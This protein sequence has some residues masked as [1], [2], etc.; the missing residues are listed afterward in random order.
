MSG[1]V[2][3]VAL[4]A[5]ASTLAAWTPVSE[6]PAALRP[7]V[8]GLLRPGGPVRQ[9]PWGAGASQQLRSSAAWAPYLDHTLLRP[10]AV[11]AEVRQLG[12]EAR[13]HRFGGACVHP[14][15]VSTLVGV[16]GD[17]QVVPIAVVGFPH[18]AHRARVKALEVQL[19]VSEGA[20][21]L[22]AVAALGALREADVDRALED[23]QAVVEAARPWPV[24]LILE[25][26]LLDRRAVVLGATLALVTGCAAV[27]TSTGFGA[28]GARVED[29]ALLRAVVGDA[30]QVKAAGGVRT[31]EQAL[32]M[33]EAGA[34][35][36]GT[37]A[38]V[39]LVQGDA[40]P[41]AIGH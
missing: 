28:P 14:A 1:T 24:K 31:R 23:I 40:A 7:E 27:K 3:R 4:R 17:A 39:W 2:D 13:A 16:L 22:D 12:E 15:H 20:R 10:D 37:S 29:V 6:F 26:G 33:V 35:R 8:F 21:E 30:L 9:L 5:F 18:G 19:A 32:A 36:L 34:S 11:L 38:S 41:L 25:T